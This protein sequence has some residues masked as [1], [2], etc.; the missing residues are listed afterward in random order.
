LAQGQP[1][2]RA[3]GLILDEFQRV[4]ELGGAQAEAQVRAAIQRHRRVGYV[5]AGSK[6]RMLTAMTM[7]P[8]HPF[9]RLGSVRFIGPVPRGDFERFLTEKFVENGFPIEGPSAVQPIL[10][11]AEEVP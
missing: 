3:V 7:D 11:F 8:D 1:K 10:R 6:T 2:S 5:F 9:Y 4:I